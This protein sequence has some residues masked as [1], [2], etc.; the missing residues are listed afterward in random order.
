MNYFRV[1]KAIFASG[2]TKY[3]LLVLVYLLHC[4][5]GRHT[6]FPGNQKI[7][8]Y[9]AISRSKATRVVDRLAARGILM[10]EN[11]SPAY[12]KNGSIPYI[13][14]IR[15]NHALGADKLIKSDTSNL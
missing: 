4:Q 10:K 12:R 6:V 3:E 11:R 14:V 9:C 8:K 5:D 2:F 1:P 15:N 7:A 13:V